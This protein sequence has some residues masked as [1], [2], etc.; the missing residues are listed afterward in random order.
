[1]GLNSFV[2]FFTPKDRIFYSIFEEV[3]DN[4]AEMSSVFCEAIYENDA[5]LRDQM[6]G[7]LE[8]Y[9]HKNDDATH[10]LFIE[11]GQNFITPFD[12]EDIHYLATALDD[13]SD[14]IWASAKS[15]VN[16]NIEEVNDTMRELATVINNS[17]G[18]LKV[19]L[20]GLR[21]MKD[22]RSITDACVKVNSFENDA[23]DIL[24]NAL[25]Q[26]F[27][28]ETNAIELIKRKELYQDMEIVTDKCEDAANVIES[29]IIKYS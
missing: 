16:Y 25:K 2:K 18:A 8:K 10:R 7:S 24:D 23:D 3:A 9:E 6:L 27:L 17:V 26:L 19:A 28:I 22:L 11:L 20:K 29:I 4:L 15:I 13:V 12:R 5:K 14:Y 21:N 1:M